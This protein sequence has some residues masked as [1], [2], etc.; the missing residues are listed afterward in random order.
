MILSVL[1]LFGSVANAEDIGKFTILSQNEAAPFEGVLFDPVATA[2]I[3][4][5]KTFTSQDCDIKLS[6]E[7]DKREIEFEL[8]RDNFNIRYES[9]R[10]EYKL[11]I[12]EKDLEISQLR[13]SLLQQSPIKGWWWATA[14]A[15]VGV[16]TTYGAYRVFNE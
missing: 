16:A 14:G 3:I 7:I 10:D 12:G 2:D 13:E 8:E 11:T 4:V 5:A 1:F 6:Y 9:L 15:V